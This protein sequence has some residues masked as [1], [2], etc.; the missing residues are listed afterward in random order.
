MENNNNEPSC[1][2]CGGV[3]DDWSRGHGDPSDD[4]FK[5]KTESCHCIRNNDPNEWF[6]KAIKLKKEIKKIKEENKKLKNRN[7]LLAHRVRLDED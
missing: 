7:L 1:L 6:D 5:P 3:V 4:D 2:F